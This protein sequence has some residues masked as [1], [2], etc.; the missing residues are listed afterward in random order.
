MGATAE[1]TA[2]ALF[3]RIRE[4]GGNPRQLLEDKFAARKENSTGRTIQG[5]IKGRGDLDLS[6]QL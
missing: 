4:L 3:A 5:P 1:Q 6:G 2:Q